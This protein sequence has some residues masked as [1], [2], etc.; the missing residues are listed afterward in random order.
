MYF[1]K[2]FEY[3]DN[4]PKLNVDPTFSSHMFQ[5]FRNRTCLFSAK[6]LF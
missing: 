4:A 5:I 6:I 3:L 1:P 2:E